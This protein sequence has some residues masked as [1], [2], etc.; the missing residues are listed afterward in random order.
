MFDWFNKPK[1]AGVTRDE[2]SDFWFTQ[3][4][5]EAAGMMVTPETA[6]RLAVVYAC[7]RFISETVGQLPL[8]VFKRERN[9]DKNA[10]PEHPIYDLLHDQPNEEH[11]ALEFREML[12]AWAVLR[13]TGM[14]EIVPGRRGAVDQLIPLHPDYIR[15]VKVQDNSN[16]VR[17]QVEYKEPGVP[18][19]RLLRDELFILRAM[20]IDPDCPLL[21]LDPI[22]VQRDTLGS[23]LAVRDYGSRF[24]QNDARPGGVIEHPSNF[25]TDDDRNAFKRAWHAA[26]GGA[27][28]HKTAVLEWGAKYHQVGISPEQAQFLETR[29]VS[30]A[31]TA[32]IFRVQPHKV[33]IM[34]NA[35]FS[36]IE[37]QAL[38]SVQDTMM[39]WLVRWEQSIKRDLIVA[40]GYFAEHNV[41]GLL[42]GDLKSRY[43]AFAI[44]RN[45][46]WL[47][48]NEIRRL[49]NQN[50]IGDEGDVYLQPLNMIEAGQPDEP[51]QQGAQ[52]NQPRPDTAAGPPLIV[53]P[54]TNGALHHD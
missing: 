42:R 21:G 9:G 39:P 53:R 26:F 24:F 31:D 1:A 22:T 28:R 29:K 47:S 45:W 19:R 6:M 18:T 34:D 8:Q 54:K 38:E 27:N 48:V 30:A 41:S 52:R 25:K 14:A 33:G 3:L 51:S 32:R 16:R 7:V 23:S 43:E 12:T 40:R 50:G 20:A 35:T 37:H 36:N 11:T 49:E 46:G 10:Q 4:G 5:R 2:R 44:A 17:W 13:G 15:C